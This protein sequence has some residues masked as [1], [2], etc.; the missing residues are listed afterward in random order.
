MY[1]CRI[2]SFSLFS[3][4]L[5]G[6]VGR[7]TFGSILL[8]IFI[9]LITEWINRNEEYGFKKQFRNKWLRRISYLLITISIFVLAG[10]QQGFIYFQF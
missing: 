10:E 6:I 3:R 2:I 4:P 9:L 8:A 7:I 5:V 1:I